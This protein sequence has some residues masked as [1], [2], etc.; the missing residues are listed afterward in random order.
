MSHSEICTFAH[1]NDILSRIEEILYWTKNEKNTWYDDYFLTTIATAVLL[2]LG[3][4]DKDL[5]LKWIQEQLTYLEKTKKHLDSVN[6]FCASCLGLLS[7]HYAKHRSKKE[8]SNLV[9]KLAIELSKI[10]WMNTP[11]TVAFLTLLLKETEFTKRVTN[12]VL[13]NKIEGYLLDCIQK[14]TLDLEHLTYALFSLSFFKPEIVKNYVIAHKDIVNKL[15]NHGRIEFRALILD[16]LDKAEIPC[17]E[18]TYQGIWNYFDRKRYGIVE[19]SII[20]KITS[21]VYGRIAGLPFDQ[22]DIKIEEGNDV[23]HIE[24][25]IAKSSLEEMVAHAPPI[26]QLSV[27]ALSILWSNYDELYLFSRQR[28][29][30]Y[31]KLMRIEKKD[32]H[33]PVEKEKLLEMSKK[34]FRYELEK[35]L[36]KYGVLTVFAIGMLPLALYYATGPLTGIPYPWS[37]AIGTGIGLFFGVGAFLKWISSRGKKEY[38]ELKTKIEKLRSE[39]K[40]QDS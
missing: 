27:V 34:I 9:K 22:R 39:G 32:T 17:A 16:A 38:D 19:R 20:Q 12:E 10:N 8:T 25:N 15:T 3:H 21:F 18:E 28:F 14:E 2:K 29:G 11:K 13:L 37:E 40:W 7:L 1:K 6:L 36:L 26:D 5:N 24:I 35:I 4:S 33:L 30:E 31:Q 23:A